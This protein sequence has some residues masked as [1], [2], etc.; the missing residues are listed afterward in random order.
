MASSPAHP[1]ARR[2]R[3]GFTL[4]ELMISIALV[5]VLILGVNQ[6]FQSTLQAVGAGQAFVDS[7]RDSRAAQTAFGAD[8]NGAAADGP[9]FV[10]HSSQVFAFR[11]R[12]DLAADKDQNANT[13][14]V[15]TPDDTTVDPTTYNTRNHRVD[16]LTFLSRG[17]FPSQ[18]GDTRMVD[19]V[20]SAEARVWYGFLRQPGS[21]Y[22]EP[23]SANLPAA[24][25]STYYLDP[26][27]PPATVGV[28]STASPASNPNNFFAT[29]W[30]LG[31]VA[32]LLIPTAVHPPAASDPQVEQYYT[33]NGYSNGLWTKPTSTPTLSAALFSPLSY[34]ASITGNDATP[35]SNTWYQ[36]S[37][38]FDVAQTSITSYT[39]QMNYLLAQFPTA[40]WWNGFYMGNFG[41]TYNISPPSPLFACN[42]FPTTITPAALRPSKAAAASPYFL[43]GCTQFTVEF[44]GDFVQQNNDPSDTANYGNVLDLV[45]TSNGKADGIDFVYNPT[46]QTRSIRWYGLPRNPT[47]TPDA[48]SGTSL[49]IPGNTGAMFTTGSPSSMTQGGVTTARTLS[50]VVPLRDV[51]ATSSAAVAT[52]NTLIKTVAAGT[53]QPAWIER[54]L[55]VATAPRDY[56][57]GGMP[58]G[59]DYLVAW[60][61]DSDAAGIPRPKMIRITFTLDD[62]SGRLS[63]GQ[64]FQFVYTLP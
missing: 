21:T 31:R 13:Y 23:T 15:T 29:D 9:F 27:L 5:V 51:I 38:R 61:P 41:S 34:S 59:Q 45:T 35:A 26:G 49:M 58:N 44:A 53:I 40:H 19:D 24:S 64:T 33:Y 11:N 30:A 52:L 36:P 4:V 1:L 10:I 6:V 22:R 48:S 28:S 42:P 20:S 62:P 60:G 25:S 2:H 17:I 16:V 14:T 50:Q 3:P 56:G 32:T 43:K 12:A 54:S 63:D 55:P 18:T 37:A 46:T 39:S 57:N 47:N 8:L 7:V